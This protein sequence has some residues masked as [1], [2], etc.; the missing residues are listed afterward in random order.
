M[1]FRR[2]V[3][4]EIGGFDLNYTGS[5][6]LEETDLSVRVKKASY[7][8]LFNPA[9]KVIHT[10]APREAIFRETFTLR[11][12]F[13]IARNSTYFMLINFGIYRTLAYIFTNDTGVVAFLKKPRLYSLCC[14]FIFI[15]GKCVGSCTGIRVKLFHRDKR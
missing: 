3:L 1:S 2:E 8:I 7:K 15:I 13:Y 10:A 14:I 9:M 11:R 5:N 6:V 4:K 12:E